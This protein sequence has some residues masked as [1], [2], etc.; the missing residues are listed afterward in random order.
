M[1]EEKLLDII[2]QVK[3]EFIEEAAPKGLPDML[4]AAT[5]ISRW[6]RS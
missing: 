2:G 6:S 1:S 3:D 5:P 4:S